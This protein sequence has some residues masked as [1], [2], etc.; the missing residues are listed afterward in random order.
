MR[1]RASL[2]GL[3][4]A[5]MAMSA[6]AQTTVTSSGTT[7]T[8]GNVPY[9]S[10]STT[11][12]TTIQP[13]P[14]SVSGGNVGIGTTAPSSGFDL[15]AEGNGLFTRNSSNNSGV[16]LSGQS[17]AFGLIQGVNYLNTATI[18]LILQQY[19]GNVGIG[20]NIPTAPLNIWNTNSGKTV[21]LQ[22]GYAGTAGAG[23]EIQFSTGPASV[24]NVGGASIASYNEWGGDS[25]GNS[26]DL[27]F[28]TNQRT[29]A[30]T[31]SGLTERM[32]VSAAGNVGI[33]TTNPGANA[34]SGVTGTFLEVKG[35]IMLT[36]QSGGSLVFADG[37]IQNK[38]WNGVLNGG[39]YAEDMR[40]TGMKE[41][42]EP[43]DVLVLA[44]GDN[45]DVQKSAE[46]YS[47]MVAGIYATKPG[48]V[49]RREAVA[50]SADNVPMAMVGVVPTKV[51]AEN[52]PIRKGDLLVSA[53][54]PGY[55]MKGT[56]R[57]RMLGAVLGKAMGSLDSGTGV[58]EVLVTLQ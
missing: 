30:N 13:S 39:D 51:S 6:A 23:P 26:A 15:T 9:V 8:T 4:L 29:G 11:T 25:N 49:G 44:E 1:T 45:A 33:G 48:V 43:G 20:A 27:V 24:S 21:L 35:N 57:S 47:A 12:S 34:P 31:Y 22:G 18:N 14:I 10:A 50:K 3:G 40:A 38:A 42:Y 55:A 2:I 19:G 58:I 53:S 16:Y 52:G 41:K 36:Q 7:A 46:P 32:R 37:S 54:L 56:D 17:G 28:K 5:L